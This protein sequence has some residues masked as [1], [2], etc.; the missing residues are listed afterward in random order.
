MRRF[1][2]PK[3]AR[4]LKFG[5]VIM[6]TIGYEFHA[7]GAPWLPRLAESCLPSAAVDISVID[8]PVDIQ[9]CLLVPCRDE[10]TQI[11]DRNNCCISL[12][13]MDDMLRQCWLR[14]VGASH[15]LVGIAEFVRQPLR[16][17]HRLPIHPNSHVVSWG[18][19]KVFEY[20]HKEILMNV[21]QSSLNRSIIGI[22]KASTPQFHTF[23]PDIGSQ[24][25]LRGIIAPLTKLRVASHKEEGRS[26]KERGENDNQRIRAFR[27]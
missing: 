2:F 10:R 9:H 20:H 27:R 12:V 21:T 15:S 18:Q 6:F 26:K 25:P 13:F 7:N 3:Q 24:L 17:W 1:S 8:M 5:F 16:I 14:L 4:M 23:D 19:S 22:I 11:D